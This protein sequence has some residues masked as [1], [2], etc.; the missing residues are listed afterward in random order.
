[1]NNTASRLAPIRKTKIVATIGP[2]CNTPEMLRAMIEAGM[3]VA[4]LNLSHGSYDN[5]RKQI[6]D[7]RA[8]ASELGKE[9]AIMIDT[10]GIEIRTGLLENN[11][12]IL[13]P[14]KSFDLRTDNKPGDASGVSITYLK[15]CEEVSRD[16]PILIDDGAIELVV[17]KITGGV[18]NCRI[19]H[20][21]LLGNCKSVNLPETQLAMSAVSPENRD[22]ILREL[23]FATENDVDYIA[24]SFVQSADDINKMR[25]ILVEKGVLIPIIAKIENKAGVLNMEEIVDAADGVMVARGDLGVELPLADVPAT[26]KSIIRT[27]VSNGKPVI[28]ATQML[29]SMEW[30]P[31]PTR[32]EASD[33]AN[34]I[35][36]GTSA[37]MLSG[38]T[39]VG[40]YPL[41]ALKMLSTIALRAEA[42]LLEYGYLQKI[43]PSPT[44]VV[45]QAIGQA[46]VNL[47]TN[48][49][50]TAIISLTE[51]G[52]TS[53]LVSK[54]RP[55]CPIIAITSLTRVVRK[56]SMNWG[57][58]PILYEGVANDEARIEFAISRI[59]QLTHASSGDI[60][61]VTAGHYQHGAGST[62][63]VRIITL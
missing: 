20:G 59:K 57:V 63:L 17:E 58:V 19:I 51:S 34:A 61:I 21:G 12:A 62:D 29:A 35:L 60:L 41:E 37:V 8:A 50:A 6:L 5:H 11:S 27:T 15:L 33:V 55:D 2:A 32:A 54:Y 49:K 40:K 22:D 38:E 9:I 18:I 48:L 43:K 31:K 47:A 16:T 14:G 42:S 13:I 3:N 7:L 53:R 4:R 28:T 23:S 56:L 24:A 1:M 10:R 46:S 36:D 52:F 25:E 44:N 39:A 45:T 26:Q 30:N